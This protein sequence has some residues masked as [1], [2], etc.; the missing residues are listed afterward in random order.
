M[1]FFSTVFWKKAKNLTI[2]KMP[3]GLQVHGLQA[4][5]MNDDIITVHMAPMRLFY[6]GK[7]KIATLLSK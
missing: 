5:S 1:D 2:L 7:I 6:S 4:S 3:Q